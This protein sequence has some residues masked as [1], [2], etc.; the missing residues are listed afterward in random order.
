MDRPP[1]TQ[2]RQQDPDLIVRLGGWLFR[3]RSWLPVPLALAILLI[4]SPDAV[5]TALWAGALLIG[6]GEAVRLWAV[7]HIGVVSR[8]RIDRSG[9]L[10]SS[11]PFGHVRNP[12]YIG[13]LALWAGFSVA[14]GLTWLTPTIVLLL[15]AK[16]HAIVRWEESL[17]ESRMGEPYR[18]YTSRVPRWIPAPAPSLS[19]RGHPFS[20]GETLF[21]ERGTLVAIV[22][23][24]V[25][26]WVKRTL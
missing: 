21:S 16:Y 1:Q 20:W 3:Q 18:R 26:L 6:M 24:G 5:P 15:G 4:P 12:L 7:R 2:V 13:N 11:G 8:T 14:A 17:L 10:V 9:P 25:L 19:P 23:G 22:V